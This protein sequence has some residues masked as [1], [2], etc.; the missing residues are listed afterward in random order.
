[1]RNPKKEDFSV[2]CDK[3]DKW[4]HYVCL[5]LTGKEV[6]LQEG[7]DLEYFC[8]DCKLFQ[9]VNTEN[10]CTSDSFTDTQDTYV[11]TSEHKSKQSCSTGAKPKRKPKLS[12]SSSCQQVSQ[13]TTRSGC[14]IKKTKKYDI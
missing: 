11:T 13:T 8:P 3:C 6:E 9:N 10:T 4:F 7:S 2:L 1:M 5:G 12:Q 14:I